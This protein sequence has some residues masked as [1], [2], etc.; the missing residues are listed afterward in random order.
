[1]LEMKQKSILNLSTIADEFVTNIKINLSDCYYQRAKDVVSRFQAFLEERQLHKEPISSI[2]VRDI[3]IFLNSFQTYKVISH[4]YYK[5]K[6]DFP[7]T[8]NL[9][10]LARQNIIDRCSSYELRRNKKSISVEKAKQICD[11]CKIDFDEYF[12]QVSGVKT[13]STETIKGYR[14]VLRTIFNEA[15]R[16]DWIA[17]N[18]VC[19]TKIGAGNGNSTLRA[20]HEKEVFSLSEAKDFIKELDKLDKDLIN[21]K[22]I[23]K[24]MILT[25]VRIAE[26][27][28]LRWSDIDFEK[29]TI[30]FNKTTV[31]LDGGGIEFQTP[32]TPNAIRTILVSQKLIDMLKDW[33]KQQ[34]KYAVELM[35]EEPDLICTRDSLS[36][37][38][39]S[40]I[41]QY[42]IKVCKQ[43]N[44][45][46]HFHQI[47]HT[48]AT[49]L[50]QNGASAKDVQLRL[51]HSKIETTLNVYV[52]N[53][54]EASR[55]S[56][57]IIDN[58]TT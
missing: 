19:Q 34:Q 55:N 32:K 37:I 54:L 26:M 33:K 17:K 9:R 3:Q 18:P 48:H 51:G 41:Q 29:N 53:D 6:K 27:C 50:I 5:L 24:F 22:M 49:M 45:D 4:G 40:S 10:E 44:I 16:Y 25:G 38:R 1:M 7:K 36:H 47:R 15:V 13:Y 56:V 46:V 12:Y 57:N 11:F 20:I 31:E 2:N 8:V 30:T 39:P 35:K 21:K 42:L 28:A 52:H 14:R 58:L 23:L 43:L